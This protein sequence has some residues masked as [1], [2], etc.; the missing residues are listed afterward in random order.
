[1]MPST[2]L[3]T[4]QGV[5]LS[6]AGYLRF[7]N[8]HVGDVIDG[9]KR[10]TIRLGEPFLEVQ[11]D[12]ELWTASGN[13]FDDAVVTGVDIVDASEVALHDF[14]YHRNYESFNEFKIEMFEYYD[15]HIDPEDT[16][17]IYRFDNN[18]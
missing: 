7:D 17:T 10:V 16:F 3:F 6:M 1:M 11:D 5:N 12:V 15:E 2:T 4:V 8:E 9:R 14:K 18:D 13:K